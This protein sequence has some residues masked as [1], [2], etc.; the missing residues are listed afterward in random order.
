VT[1]ASAN[2]WKA[3]RLLLM[4]AAALHAWPAAA[5]SADAGPSPAIA[6]FPIEIADTSGEPPNPGWPARVTVVTDQLA[7]LL[8]ASG[9]YRAVDLAPVRDRLAAAGPVH[10]CGGCWRD[11]AREVGA[12]AVAITVVHK[13]STLISSMHVWLLDVA[14]Q[15]TIRRGAVSLR[16]DTEEAWR[17]SVGFLLRRGILDEDAARPTLSSP[18]PGG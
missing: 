8:V 15:R 17:R 10:R 12:E 11:L 18:F 13:M 14:T 2:G 3:W 9:K 5:E 4:L 6:V 1:V 7:Q 16:G